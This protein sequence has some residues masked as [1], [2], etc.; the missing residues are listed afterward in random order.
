M[1]GLIPGLASLV[2]TCTSILCILCL[3]VFL[4]VC[5][6]VFIFLETMWHV[7][8]SSKDGLVFSC[9]FNTLFCSIKNDR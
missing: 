5:V 8:L 1:L 6:C 9:T 3:R 4:Y 2:L 7:G